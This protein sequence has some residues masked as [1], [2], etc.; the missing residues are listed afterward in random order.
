ML[1]FEDDSGRDPI[2]ALTAYFLLPTAYSL[3]TTKK[4]RGF[5]ASRLSSLV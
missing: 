1:R 4:K 2:P 5:A 3:L